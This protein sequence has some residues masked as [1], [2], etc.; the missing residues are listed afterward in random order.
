[1]L[2]IFVLSLSITPTASG[3]LEAISRVDRRGRYNVFSKRPSDESSSDESSFLTLANTELLWEKYERKQSKPILNLSR[4]YEEDSLDLGDGLNTNPLET[5]IVSVRPSVWNQ[6]KVGLLS[7][8]IKFEKC[9]NSNTDVYHVDED[10]FLKIAPQLFRLESSIVLGTA[11]RLL[12]IMGNERGQQMIQREPRLLTFR[13]EHVSYGFEFLSTMMGIKS[14][15]SD[16]VPSNYILRICYDKPTL[17]LAGIEGGI[18]EKYVQTTLGDAGSA[19]SNAN[20][21]IVGDVSSLLK[22]RKEMN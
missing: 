11:S 3:Y 2:L 16:F 1:M 13:A 9:T 12:D 5:Y 14:I 20:K 18:Q 4:L 19:V 15:D 22:N 17:L 6:T 8:G 10:A 21:R 7:M